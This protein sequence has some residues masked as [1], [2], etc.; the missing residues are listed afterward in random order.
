MPNVDKD[1]QKAAVKEAL[2]EWLDQTFAVF[3]K[4][5]FTSLMALAFAGA[6]YMALQGQGWKK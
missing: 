2:H 4:W 5:T 1:V 3:G 6:V